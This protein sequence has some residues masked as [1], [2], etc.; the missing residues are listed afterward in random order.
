EDVIREMTEKLGTE[1]AKDRERHAKQNDE[2]QNPTFILRGQHQV[3]D[4][5]A[6][7]EDERGLRSAGDFLERLT[8]PLVAETRRQRLGRQVFHVLQCLSG[9]HARSRLALKLRRS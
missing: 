5:D 3:D 1:R 4:E 2:R 8:G 9:A 7:R 6:E